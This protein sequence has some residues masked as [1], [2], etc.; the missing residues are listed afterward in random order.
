MSRASRDDCTRMRD[1]IAIQRDY[2]RRTSSRF[3]EMHLG[4]KGEHDFALAFMQS[5]I[6]FLDIGSM[7]DVGAGTGRALVQIKKSHANLRILGVEP[8]AAQRDVGYTKGLSRQELIEGDAQQLQFADGAFD[9]VCE[10][11]ALHHMTD[12]GKAVSEMLRVA[13]KA[14]FISDSNNFGQGSLASRTVKQVLR[15]IGLWRVADLIK[16]RGR[17]YT[18]SE[19]DGL[20]YSYSVFNNYP[21]IARR[22]KSVHLVNTVAAGTNLYRSAGHI[23]LLGIK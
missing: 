9:L 12:P 22:C 20:F 1:E 2:Y 14:I 6:D 19:G 10:F 5:M 16:T 8:S 11:G 13:R 4:S 7:L 18:L 21:E 17:G 15:S 3:D 23:A